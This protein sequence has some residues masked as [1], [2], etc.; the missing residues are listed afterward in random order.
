[1][2]LEKFNNRIK[3]VK[4][5][6]IFHILLFIIALPCSCIFKLFRKHIWLFCEDKYEA[7]DNAYW[8]FKYTRENHPEIDAV[9][10]INP[11][12]PDAEKVRKLGKVIKYGSLTHWIYYLASNKQI[13]SHKGGKPNSA[14]CYLLEI[15]GILKN[16]RVF[17]Q[18]GITIS[19][20]KWLYYEV[21]KFSLFVTAVKAEYEFVEKTFGYENKQVVK[22]L[23]FCRYDN[24]MNHIKYLKPKQIL[25]M[26]TWRSWIAKSIDDNSEFQKTEYFKS[27]YSLLNNQ[28]LQEYLINNG[29]QLVFYP[30]RQMQKYIS[31]FKLDCSSITVPDFKT[32]GVQELLME[33]AFL[34]TDYSSINIDFAYMNKPLVY[35]Q[36]DY[37]EYR[38][39]QYQEGYFSYENDGFGEICYDEKALIAKI[40]EYCSSQFALKEEYKKRIN[41]FFTFHDNNN[42]E[43]NFNAIK[44]L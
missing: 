10:A 29:Y 39:K 36:F 26:P 13:S 41:S 8:L 20:L 27:W 40:K 5:H 38:E 42:C 28:D 44:E 43:R 7:R 34:I 16:K 6:D 33:S 21:C 19:D 11:K 24:L 9:Y 31:L 4:I 18:H 1:M 17:L 37:K 23:G 22:L 35:Y 3:Y 30:H 2:S 12:C 32:V 15:S 25:I 14:V